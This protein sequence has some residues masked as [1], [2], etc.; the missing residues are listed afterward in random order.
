MRGR[1]RD[2]KETPK[3]INDYKNRIFLVE[4]WPKLKRGVNAGDFS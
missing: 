3:K 2:D 1:R 4:Q